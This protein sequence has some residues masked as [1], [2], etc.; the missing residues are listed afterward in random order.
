MYFRINERN[1]IIF[2]FF[3]FLILLLFF[4]T[5]NNYII[6]PFKSIHIPHKY[7]NLKLENSIEEILSI[8]NYERIYTS[9]SF[10]TPCISLDFYFSMEQYSTSI[11]KNIYSEDSKIYESDIID[12]ILY[13]DKCTIYKDLNLT[14]N[15]TI[16]PVIFFSNNKNINNEICS[17]NEKDK[18]YGIIGL[19]RYPNNSDFNFKSFIYSLKKYNYINSYS[20]GFFFFEDIDKYNYYNDIKDKYDGFF[21][22]GTTLDDK[23]DIFDTNLVYTVYAEEDSLNWAIYFDRIFYY[24][25]INE[26]IEYISTNNTKAEFLIDIN[27]IISDIQYYEDIKKY[28]FQKFFDNNTCYEEKMKKNEKYIYMIICNINFKDN[29]K[30]FP[31]IYFYNEQLFFAFNLNYNDLFY[32]YS[33]KIY[34]L[35]IRKEDITNYWQIGKIF[36]KKYPLMFDYDKKIVSY[37]HLNKGWNPKKHN[38]NPDKLLKDKTN[39]KNKNINKEYTIYI[40]LLIGIIIGIIIGRRIWNKKKKLKANELEEQYTSFNKEN[41]KENKEILIE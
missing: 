16:N 22:A 2:L 12:K 41:K 17:L 38:K 8:I 30:T 40:F 39:N 23:I 27:Y 4:K 11:I 26:S 32:E 13:S 3:H 5:S 25:K 10:G 15:I 1:N 14:E 20:F 9:I 6:L 31:A 18:F 7:N 36:L 37:V 24:G 28:Y 21:I 35:V 34:F 33:G 29:M 19:S